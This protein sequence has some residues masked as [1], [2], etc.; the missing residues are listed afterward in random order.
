MDL[1]TLYLKLSPAKRWRLECWPVNL[2]LCFWAQLFLH[3][4]NW[5]NTNIILLFYF[6]SGVYTLILLVRLHFNT[7]VWSNCNKV[8]SARIYKVFWFWLAEVYWS[9]LPSLR[10]EA[11]SELLYYTNQNCIP[12]VSGSEPRSRTERSWCWN[13]LRTAP[14]HA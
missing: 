5:S 13:Q 6:H 3:H 7:F 10:K 9:I 11:P 1:L 2:E 8:S 14:V 12:P 4:T